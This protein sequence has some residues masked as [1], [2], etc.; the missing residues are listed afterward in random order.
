MNEEHRGSYEGYNYERK[1]NVRKSPEDKIL[2]KFIDKNNL[3]GQF[4]EQF[5]LNEDRI[6][7]ICVENVRE[8]YQISRTPIF[9]KKSAKKYNIAAISRLNSGDT[10]WIIEIKSRLDKGAIGQVLVYAHNFKKML[11]EKYNKKFNVKKAVIYPQSR[12]DIEEV[13]EKLDI[14]LFVV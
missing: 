12:K 14:K 3:N 6:D 9:I 11:E 8:G 4:I 1:E 7:A 13:C 10:F 5:P 2:Q